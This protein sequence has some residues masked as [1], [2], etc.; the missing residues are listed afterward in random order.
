MIS[1]RARYASNAAWTTPRG[2]RMSGVAVG[3]LGVRVKLEDQLLLDVGVGLD[4][5]IELLV[6]V[7]NGEYVSVHL[8]G[9]ASVDFSRL[10]DACMGVVVVGNSMHPANKDKLNIQIVA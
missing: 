7:G 2:V 6:V 10:L 1:S 9:I 5:S 8:G 4:V 3:V